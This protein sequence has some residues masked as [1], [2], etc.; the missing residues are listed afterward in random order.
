MDENRTHGGA[1]ACWEASTGRELWRTQFDASVK[2][3]VVHQ[4]GRVIA[5]TVTGEVVALDAQSG[6]RLWTYQLGE[7]SQRWMFSSP[8][9]LDDRLFVGQGPHFAALDAATGQPRWVRTDL[10]AS[11]WISCYVS[12]TCDG[13]RVFVGFHWQKNWLYALDVRTGATV[14][15]L[16]E[17]GSAVSPLVLDGR[18]GLFVT[19]QSGLSRLAAATGAQLWQSSLAEMWSPAT[20]C[21]DGDVVYAAGGAGKVFAFDTATGKTSWEWECCDDL[22]AMHPY[23]RTGKTILS[24]PTIVG[25]QILIGTNDGRLVAL[26]RQT[27]KPEWEHDFG[28]P[29]T[30]TPAF[31]DGMIFLAVRD[32]NFYALRPKQP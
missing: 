30:S 24:S 21:V 4:N 22:S 16:Q 25:D 18:G 7:P 29:V 32:G 14:W 15:R 9:A 28:A 31:A 17:Q 3:S 10:T 19:R 8:C 12:P 6:G 27:G 1:V 5:V 23:R 11:D 20:P 26:R 13:E 2:N